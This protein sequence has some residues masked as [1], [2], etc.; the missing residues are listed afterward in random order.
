[1]PAARAVETPEATALIFEAERLSHAALQTRANRIAHVLR[2]MGVTRGDPVGLSLPRSAD[3]V[4]AV[5]GIW[6]AGAAYVPMDPAYPADR[7]AFYLSDS[8]ARVVIARSDM[9]EVPGGAARAE[10]PAANPSMEP[11]SAS[12]RPMRLMSEV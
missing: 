11:P 3:M 9:D 4:A 5:L 2:A 8:G 10:I 6:K 1:M 12:T 7:L